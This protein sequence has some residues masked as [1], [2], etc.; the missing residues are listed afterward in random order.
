[1]L[2][3]FVI[4]DVIFTLNRDVNTFS[5]YEEVNIQKLHIEW[6][7]DLDKKIINGTA[8]YS[9]NVVKSGV[10]EIDLDIYQLDILT[11]YDHSTGSVLTHQ[12]ENMGEQSLK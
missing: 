11:V 12:I 10:K 3:F 9:F 1:M 2:L 6:L 8:E 4:I 7:L 5:N